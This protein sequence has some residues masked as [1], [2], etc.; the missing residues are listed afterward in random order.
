MMEKFFLAIYDFLRN[1]R[2]LLIG[3]LLTTIAILSIVGV[4]SMS[5]KEDIL[6]FLPSD[7]E[8]KDVNWA[9]SHIGA[10]NKV[11]I[12]ISPSDSSVDS[13]VLMDAVDSLET[14]IHRHVPEGLVKSVFA[15]ADMEKVGEVTDFIVDNLPYYLT[16]SEYAKLDS[17]LAVGSLDGELM[18]ARSIIASPA[19]G[20]MKDILLRDPL[21]L[22]GTRLRNLES[23]KTGTSFKTLDDYIFTEDGD[24]LVT[25]DLTFGT[26]DTGSAAVFVKSM[27]KALESTRIAMEDRVRLDPLGSVYIA[28][29]NSSQIKWDSI[30]SV[31]IA[32]ILIAF[33][34]I[35]FFKSFRSIL[36]VGAA[37]MFG[38]LVAI[39][40]TSLIMGNISLIV[41]GI[42]AVII[43]IA[44][45]YPLHFIA[46]V[47]QG[48]SARDSLSD[49]V[50]PLTT[51]NIT[52]VG[53]F[54][55]LL[56]IA[57]PAMRDLGLFS[58]LLLVGT[59][60][61]TLIFLPHL[62]KESDGEKVESSAFWDRISRFN[63]GS[64]RIVLCTVLVITV[65]LSFFDGEVKFDTDLHNINYMT[66][67]QKENMGKMLSLA[68]GN[69]SVT[70]IAV[71]GQDMNQ[72][73]DNYYANENA[74]ESL[75]SEVDGVE[76]VTSLKDFVPSASLQQQRLERWNAFVAGHGE[77]LKSMVRES[78]SRAGFRPDAFSP[79]ESLL[80]ADYQIMDISC[81][82]P[83]T[84]N[85]AAGLLIQDNDKCAVLAMAGSDA[86]K[87]EEIS[88]CLASRGDVLVF[89][90][91]SLTEN[92][93]KSLSQE[94]DTVLYF[95]AFIVFLLLVISFGRLELACIAFIPLTLGWI[96]ILGMMSILGIDFNIVN[97]I[98]ATF[99]FGMG[100]DY[101][102]FIT[103]GVMY[104]HTYGKKMLHT[105]EKTILL[106]ALIMFV[107]IGSLIVAKHPAMRSLAYVIIIGMF[108]VV[109]MADVLPPFLYRFLTMKK[110]QK[111]KEPLT[112]ANVGASLG[113]FIVFLTGTLIL[114]LAGFFLITLTFGSK[115][116][117]ILYHKLLA[118]I[119]RITFNNVFFTSHSVECSETFD[120]PAVIVANHQSYLDLMATLMLNPKMIVV[121]NR[122]NWNNPFYGIL[123][124]Y[125]DFCPVE[126][127]LSDDMTE[128][129]AKINDGYSILVFPEGTR[130]RNG[131]I[132]RFHR[133]AFYLA[134]KYSMDIVPVVLHGLNDVLPKEDPLLRK[135]HMTV[136]V[137]DRIRPDDM[138]FGNGNA[139]IAKSVRHLMIDEYDRIASNVENT[140]Y[141]AD[142]VRH[143]YI[144]KGAGIGRS[145]RRVLKM[146]DNYEELSRML[147]ATGKALFVNPSQGEPSLICALAHKSLG[148]NAV[149][150]DEMTRLLASNCVGVPSNLKYFASEEECDGWDV[151]VV[152]YNDGNYRIEE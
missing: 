40:L 15:R 126:S 58:A 147:P 56:F 42:G 52:T 123:V 152:F 143:N 101:T 57:S 19:G 3:G 109:L 61:F 26:G 112:L 11:V 24:A 100:D 88:A 106:S 13:Y 108:S 28:Y 51:G 66:S 122:R 17:L 89:D 75:R 135:G 30:I 49:I 99:I 138:S 148:I 32:V 104:E 14:M 4:S 53:A 77:Q 110:G 140:G 33:L 54:L 63:L 82:S 93:V 46:H 71:L 134:E 98:L 50:Q 113:A 94:F 85:V 27:D 12:T 65:V 43:G 133:G 141:F 5:F 121:T 80:D 149:I 107:G 36:L 44:A 132:G 73:L 114:T 84:D 139:A 68:Q 29:T 150:E 111:Q 90:S 79:F 105:Y 39:S 47:R 64:N 87:T 117:K 70:Y 142:R 8:N 116:G 7:K 103:E 74:I 38:F 2:G 16:D 31:A 45:N 151:K 34:L 20:M 91:T 23:F 37:I 125:A 10:A 41:L 62:V 145:A 35:S 59:I 146:H 118:G 1:R 92:M 25:V 55:S 131:K 128:I 21:F 6:D 120:K 144:Y 97:I 115:K 67:R 18:T 72:A 136:K 129:E 95:C 22:S 102:I 9:F 127:F 69:R 130:S 119:C 60:L 96:W 48:Y 76:T 137:L 124:R 78:A 86:D 81:F 83:I